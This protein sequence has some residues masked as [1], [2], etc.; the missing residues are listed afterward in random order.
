MGGLS[1]AISPIVYAAF[2]YEPFAQPAGQL[3]ENQTDW[4]AT[5]TTG[6]SPALVAESLT[7][8]NLATSQGGALSLQ[9][10][11]RKSLVGVLPSF[12]SG[13]VY[14]SFAFQILSQP[15]SETIFSRV[16]TSGGVYASNVALNTIG[17]FAKIG[18]GTRATSPIAYADANLT[19]NTTYFVVTSYQFDN[20]SGQSLSQL[21]LF[22]DANP[23]SSTPPPAS[24][25]G[26]TGA[27]IANTSRIN[28]R[29]EASS[30]ALL[31][32]EFRYG[33]SWA[34][35]APVPEP[36]SFISLT[37]STLLLLHRRRA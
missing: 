29:G 18:I 33:N 35:V 14:Y 11:N 1:F 36:S 23:L 7:F 27:A 26:A 5:G 20:G 30:P 28:L 2:S 17:G 37:I 34:S 24:A 31:F 22:S 25:I 19:L 21:W 10:G 9:A 6:T 16:G 32:D 15:S 12:N 8:P 13:T 3:L 4:S